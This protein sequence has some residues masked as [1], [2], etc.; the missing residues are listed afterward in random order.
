MVIAVNGSDN[1]YTHTPT[2]LLKMQYIL[3]TPLLGKTLCCCC[4]LHFC[5]GTYESGRR[6]FVLRFAFYP[7]KA[8][9][10]A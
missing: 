1:K 4:R 6:P 8:A 10:A 2:G 7:P 3:G 5:S 9:T